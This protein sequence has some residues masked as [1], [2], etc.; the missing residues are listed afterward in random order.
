MEG[1]KK[2]RD[3]RYRI[4]VEYLDPKTGRRCEIDRIVAAENAA[5]AASLRARLLAERLA[6]RGERKTERVRLRDALATWRKGKAL[7]LRPSTADRYDTAIERWN[8]AIGDYFLDALRP[9]DVREVQ[10]GWSD[11]GLASETNNGR[12]RVLRTFAGEY[13]CRWAVDGVHALPAELEETDEGRGLTLDELRAVLS[14]GPTAARTPRGRLPV[15]WPRAWALLA[16]IAWTGLRPG[17]ATALEWRDVDLDEGTLRVRRAV[18]RGIVGHPKARASKRTVPLV[19]SLVGTLREHREVMLRGQL[20]GVDSALVFP[21]RIRDATYVTNTHARKAMLKVCSAAGVELGD[22]PALYCLRHTMNNLVRQHATEQVRRSIIGHED[23]VRT[24]TKIER[25]EQREAMGAI[26]QL[27]SRG[28][29]RGS[30][31]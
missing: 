29:S 14:I 23:E 13:P 4:R 22:R 16:T 10:A 19:P 15:Y 18:W 26:V 25:A 3:G 27:V 6:A 8:D 28:S 30:V 17:E 21:S 7:T 1:V 11:A 2:R 20:P 5:A 31:Q 9:D 12:L 24:Y